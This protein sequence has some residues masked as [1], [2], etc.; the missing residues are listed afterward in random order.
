MGYFNPTEIT[1]VLYNIVKDKGI[2]D[3]VYRQQRPQSIEDKVS[4]FI[5]VTTSSRVISNTESGEVGRFG[6]GET[7]ATV[8]LY[9]KSL[10]NAVYP[11][12]MDV[13]SEELINIFPQ[14]TAQLHYKIFYVTPPLYD[15]V[16]FYA[17]SVLSSVDIFKD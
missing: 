13:L 4:S 17:M 9:V 5:V 10:P 6:A 8:T 1:T 12:L 16:G 2:V 7:I 15:N 11:P 3:E 14:S